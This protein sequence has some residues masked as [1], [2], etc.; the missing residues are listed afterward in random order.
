MAV[1]RDKNARKKEA[2]RYAARLVISENEVEK[3]K[4]Q[5]Q[6]EIDKRAA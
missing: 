2:E 4:R 1:E 6:E 5:E 3:K